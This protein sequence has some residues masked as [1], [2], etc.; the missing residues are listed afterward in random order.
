M[1]SDRNVPV[2]V[3]MDGDLKPLWNAIGESRV[4]GL[5]SFSPTPDNDTQRST[6]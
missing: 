4:G 1:L 5:D 3:H 2:F 6:R